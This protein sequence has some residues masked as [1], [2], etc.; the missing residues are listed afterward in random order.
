MN[1]EMKNAQVNIILQMDVSHK[2]R[3]Q[4]GQMKKNIGKKLALK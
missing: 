3:T 2:K 4:R 1:V